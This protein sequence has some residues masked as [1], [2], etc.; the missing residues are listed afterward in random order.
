MSKYSIS[1]C[2]PAWNLIPIWSPT[3]ANWDQHPH[4]R[5]SGLCI[6]LSFNVFHLRTVIGPRDYITCITNQEPVKH[7][8]TFTWHS[9][10]LQLPQDPK[11]MPLAVAPERRSIMTCAPKCSCS[12]PQGPPLEWRLV[13]RPG[14]SSCDTIFSEIK[15]LVLRKNCGSPVKSF[16]ALTCDTMFLD[17]LGPFVELGQMFST[18]LNRQMRKKQRETTRINRCWYAQGVQGWGFRRLR[19]RN[20][21]F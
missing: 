9:G 3:R 13:V 17:M 15:S 16:K 10:D 1:S 18:A 19:L 21:L 5:Q 8:M 2:E 4:L 11:T 14:A 7:R 6:C 12:C 20:P